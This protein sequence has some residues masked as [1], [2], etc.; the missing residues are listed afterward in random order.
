MQKRTNPLE[1]AV[2]EPVEV[3]ESPVIVMEEEPRSK[4]QKRVNPLNLDNYTKPIVV[5][6]EEPV[7]LPHSIEG[8]S[9]K[10]FVLARVNKTLLITAQTVSGKNTAEL[11]ETAL[12]QYLFKEQPKAYEALVAALNKNGCKVK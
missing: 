10:K 5:K 3:E 8:K 7:A 2:I 12:L 4:I 1:Q 6:K 11:L 9:K